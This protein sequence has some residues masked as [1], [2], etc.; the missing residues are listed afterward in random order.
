[1][2]ILIAEDNK[3]KLISILSTIEKVGIYDEDID[4]VATP[5]EAILFI[6][7]KH[8][9]FFILDMSL[10][11]YINES[12]SINSLSGKKILQT[13]KHKKISIPTI[14][15]T[16]WDVFGHHDEALPLDKL[17]SDLLKEFEGTL[18]NVILWDPSDTKWEQEIFDFIGKNKE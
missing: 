4:V 18:H 15:L 5:S 10:P 6:R 7:K 16:Q 11:T 13:M 12:H 17:S 9:D 3:N 14:V 1:M 2:K 8:F